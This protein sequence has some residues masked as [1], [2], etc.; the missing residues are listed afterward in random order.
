MSMNHR[1]AK[2]QMLHLRQA[3][4]CV[5]WINPPLGHAEYIVR[6]NGTCKL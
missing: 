6:L 2:L 4:T 3:L 5:K 1:N